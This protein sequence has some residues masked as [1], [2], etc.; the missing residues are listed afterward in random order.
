MPKAPEHRVGYV[1][2]RFP[3][4]SETFILNEVLEMEA[5][6]RE[7]EIYSI[8][9]PRD[10]K[11][12]D[13]VTR[14]QASIRY[15]PNIFDLQ[16]LWRYNRKAQQRFGWTYWR[17]LG[18]CLL[19]F[20]PMLVWRFLQ[21]AYVAER[22]VQRKLT[23]FHAHFANRAASV[24]RMASK[25]SGIPYSFTA[26]AVDIFKEPLN[27]SVLRKKI[28]DAKFVVTVS[29]SNKAYLEDFTNGEPDKILRIYNGID[30]DRFTPGDGARSKRFNIL[31]VARFVEKK[32]LD[33]LIDA[34][35]ELKRAGIDFR[36]MIVG[37]GMMR[38]KLVD[39]IAANDLKAEV[40][41][42]GVHTQE[43]IISRHRAADL[44]VL[45]CVVGEDGDRDGLPVSIVEALA[46]GV[47]V[48]STPVSGIPEAV[49]DGVNGLIVPEGDRAAL[50]QAMRRMI[51]EPELRD[52]LA[53]AARDSVVEK[54]SS[55]AAIRLL[56]ALFPGGT[57]ALE[58]TPEAP[59][60]AVEKATA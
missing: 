44:F 40:K 24:A 1:L 8:L 23:H 54:F 58:A 37:K 7:I 14:L 2:R 6:G 43:Q 13:G 5:H 12:H 50:A 57:A 48:V 59:P 26:H 49:L 34:C 46:C 9:Q 32:G 36:C 27:K 3:S 21:G 38:Q 47:P 10:P 39:Q 55:H 22:A 17:L 15:I 52:R 29:D 25:L 35:A 31:C 56:N 45:P 53:A 51:E 28:A 42:L 16:S 60:A 20:R 19:T 41:L 33:V 18:S 4:I 30:L 11:Y